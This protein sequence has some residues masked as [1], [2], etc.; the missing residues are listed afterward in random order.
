MW[1]SYIS[2][3]NQTAA[4]SN[5]GA[6]PLPVDLPSLR[7]HAFQD[8]TRLLCKFGTYRTQPSCCHRAVCFSIS[9]ERKKVCSSIWTHAIPGL[10]ELPLL[11]E[12]GTSRYFSYRMHRSGTLSPQ[13]YHVPLTSAGHPNGVLTTVLLIRPCESGEFRLPTV[14]LVTNPD[15]TMTTVLDGLLSTFSCLPSALCT[16]TIHHHQEPVSLQHGPNEKQSSK[17]QIITQTS[18]RWLQEV[19]GSHHAGMETI[20]QDNGVYTRVCEKVGFEKAQ[21]GPHAWSSSKDCI[22]RRGEEKVGWRCKSNYAPILSHLQ[23]FPHTVEI[24]ES[25]GTGICVVPC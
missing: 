3:S 15:R 11:E 12:S 25:S 22:N 13:Q 7:R 17:L 21:A 1:A 9:C 24:F 8:P 2:A 10:G 16:A 20:Q 4:A 6:V 14:S 18:R 23:T 19:L 5:N